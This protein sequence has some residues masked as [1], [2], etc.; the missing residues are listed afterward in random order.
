MVFDHRGDLCNGGIVAVM[1]RNRENARVSVDGPETMEDDV[2]GSRLRQRI[3]TGS[4]EGL[5]P[6]V[7]IPANR[8]SQ[9]ISEQRVIESCLEECGVLLSRV[10]VEY[11]E[12]RN[13]DRARLLL[14]TCALMRDF[15]D[16]PI[17]AV[18]VGSENGEGERVF[19]DCRSPFFRCRIA[20]VFD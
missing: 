6:T 18:R 5:P 11:C 16:F 8:P 9:F 1:K 15:I 10:C 14:A 3:S 13:G 2:A 4:I 19:H 12:R 20:V 17:Y 7:P